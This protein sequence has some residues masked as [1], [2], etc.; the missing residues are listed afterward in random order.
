[1]SRRTVPWASTPGPHQTVG[2]SVLFMRADTTRR[3]QKRRDERKGRCVLPLAGAR[4]AA[5]AR[6]MSEQTLR[7]PKP[8]AA[9]RT[10]TGGATPA[11][12]VERAF[13]LLDLLAASEAGIS[14]SQVARQLDMSKGS[15]HGLLKT[16]ERVGAIAVDI[17]RHYTLGPQIYD[18]A[19][20]YIRRSG[21]RRFALPAMRRL[22]AA[23]AETV[24]LGRIESDGVRIIERV[25]E[26]GEGAT[27]GVTARRGTRIHPLAGATGRVVLASWPAARRVE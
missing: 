26:P 18:L 1:M 4:G 14:L 2:L 20:A 17:D 5:T 16:L 23:S 13:R 22:A 27:L 12:M 7:G 9:E 10:T 11:P 15:V 19:Q 6:V 8:G 25:E 21:L 24:F 3:G